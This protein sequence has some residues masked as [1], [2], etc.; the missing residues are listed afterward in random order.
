MRRKG[1]IGRRAGW[2]GL[3]LA[4]GL[5]GVSAKA[6]FAQ[7]DTP[8][9]GVMTQS[10]DD[11]LRDGMSY[12]G[13]GVLVSRVVG[14]QAAER[15][16]IRKGDVIVS[17]N[18]RS[19]DSPDELSDLIRDARVGQVMSVVVMRD[20][21]RRTLSARLGA[22]PED[23]QG[24]GEDQ[25][26]EPTWK[27]RFETDRDH[28]GMAR[29]MKELHEADPDLEGMM[30]SYRDLGN[31]YSFSMGRGRLGLRLEDMS[32]DL[33]PYFDAP[34]SSG[35]LVMEVMKGTPAEKAGIKAG[36]VVVQVEDTKVSDAQDVI[37]AMRRA[38]KGSVSVTVL[39]KGVRRT[40]EPELE[41]A[42]MSWRMNGRDFS[43]LA[44]RARGDRRIVVRR[45]GEAPL[46]EDLPRVGSDA[47]RE[48]MRKMREEI[49]QLR[50]KVNRLENR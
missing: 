40:F 11:G 13:T 14:G 49:R 30:K 41:E 32:E 2:F 50:E 15:A 33:S 27:E 4:L 21:Q 26:D 28:E 46:I 29:R 36:D 10:L 8:W 24:L 7:T 25:G 18:A 9:L 20:G 42:P 3:V 38:P 23:T 45:P 31:S 47:T 12:R 1:T 48:E 16:G 43:M 35:A 17:V 39:R 19:I 34:G 22:R 6:S 37:D 44:P 5:V